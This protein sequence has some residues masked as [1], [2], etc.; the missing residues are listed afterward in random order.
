M[1]ALLHSPKYFNDVYRNSFTFHPHLL[2]LHKT[3]NVKQKPASVAPTDLSL[4]KQG[5]CPHA[6]AMFA[7]Q[8]CRQ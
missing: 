5:T 3:R 4:F 7:L 8:K 6:T 2:A 1:E